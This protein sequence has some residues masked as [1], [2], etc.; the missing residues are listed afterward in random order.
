MTWHPAED[1]HAR[2]TCR[3]CGAPGLHLPAIGLG[4]RHNLGE[5]KVTLRARPAEPRGRP[6]FRRKP[7]RGRIFFEN[8]CARPC[9][10]APE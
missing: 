3:R 6:G 9:P 8:P 4:L 10:G 7:G 5:E 2:M 1:R